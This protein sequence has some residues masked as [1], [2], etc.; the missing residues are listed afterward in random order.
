MRG[1]S[2]KDTAGTRPVPAGGCGSPAD[3]GERAMAASH[4]DH[5]GRS[6]PG[7]HEVWEWQERLVRF[8]TRDRD[9]AGAALERAGHQ[10]EGQWVHQIAMAGPGAAWP[11]R[12]ILA[13]IIEGASA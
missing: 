7:M 13:R 2:D 1:T 9:R 10:P 4:H 12:P 6:L 3:G 11:G 8:G 5:P